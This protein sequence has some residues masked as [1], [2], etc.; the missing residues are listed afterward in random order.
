V[1]ASRRPA[2]SAQR[3]TGQAVGAPQR[4][5]NGSSIRR[6]AVVQ[7]SQTCAPGRKQS[8]QRCGRSRSS[9]SPR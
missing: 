1:K 3:F 7:P 9:T 6:R 2:H 4:S 5:Q 8:R